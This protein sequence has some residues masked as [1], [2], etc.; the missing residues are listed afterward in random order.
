MTEA[1]IALGS[2]M[3]DR[4]RHLQAAVYALEQ[5]PGLTMGA[6]SRF[7]ET[8]PVG[9]P[10]GQGPFLNAACRIEYED[11]PRSLLVLLQGIEASRGRVRE[12]GDQNA[13]GPRTL[14]LDLLLFGDE[15]IDLPGL[16]VPHPRMHERD[17]VLVPLAEFAPEAMHPVLKLSVREL[18]AHLHQGEQLSSPLRDQSSPV[19][20]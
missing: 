16:T 7:H 10:P 1:H 20:P 3:G 2:N 12:N 5:T 19:D 17:F 8:A 4:A 14:D 13:W 18:L 11:N 9:G 6:V 15:I